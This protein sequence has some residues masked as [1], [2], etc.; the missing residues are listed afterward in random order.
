MG[1]ELSTAGIKVKYCVE[2]TAGTRPTSGYT[3]LPGIKSIPEFGGEP[4]TLETTTL[5][6]EKFKTYISA[7]Q[8][9]GGAIGFTM[10][11]YSDSKTAWDGMV[12]E[13]T[14]ASASGLAIWIEYAIPGM[15]S[16]FYR[17]KPTPL[18]FGGADV[19]SVLEATG[20]VTPISEPEWASAST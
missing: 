7:L 20:Y 15:D 18:S 9:P 5:D 4:A 3:M 19:D 10:N 17:A 6:K 16:F 2:T 14:T 12:T 8:D 13:Y 11:F 1:I